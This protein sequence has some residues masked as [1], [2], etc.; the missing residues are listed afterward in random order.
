[1]IEPYDISTG[2]FNDD[3]RL[4]LAVSSGDFGGLHVLLGSATGFFPVHD[5]YLSGNTCSGAA[6]ADVDQDGIDDLIVTHSASVGTPNQLQILPGLGSAGT[7]NG[8]FGT[9]VSFTDCCTPVHVISGDFDA[10]GRPDFAT[11]AYSTDHLSVFLDGC[12]PPPGPPS[13]V[14]IRD[15]PNDQGGKVFLTWTRSAFD[16]TGG[17]VNAYRVWRQ[18]PPGA[19]TETAL[20]AADEGR[21][22]IRRELVTHADGSTEIVFWEA[23][24]TLPAQ[25]LAGYGYTAATPQDSIAGSNP[26]FTFS[27]SALTNNIDVFYDSAPD[28]GY[29]VDNVAPGAVAGLVASRTAG[30]A[31][32][33]WQP[34]GAPDLAGYHVHRSYDPAFVPSA[35][36]LLATVTQP[37]FHD[38]EGMTASYRICAVDAHGNMSP[39]ASALAATTDAGPRPAPGRTA[40]A[41]PRPNPVRAALDV[42][43][44]L[45]HGSRVSL[46]LHD[47]LGRHV[48]TLLDAARPPGELT[49]RWD[50][51]DDAEQRVAPGVYFLRMRAD[52]REQVRRVTVVR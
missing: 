14:R 47:Q 12:S 19:L 34:D 37:S 45:A 36:T 9:P 48:R 27:V 42:R 4:D 46:A 24:A 10:D 11:C 51:R 52:G 15:V 30:A 26:R 2:D 49:L 22:D 16:V 35:A 50:L 39:F 28:S 21:A 44:S 40:L 3:G 8:T 33:D 20:A 7:G 43:L 32:L 38:P 5:V 23:L 25:R 29:S 41:A 31:Q 18:V 1:G 6:V 13:I 17:A